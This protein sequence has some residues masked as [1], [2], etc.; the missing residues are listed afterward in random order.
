MPTSF[1]FRLF[2]LPPPPPIIHT[3]VMMYIQNGRGS[4]MHSHMMRTSF[5]PAQPTSTLTYPHP[6]QNAP[7]QMAPHHYSSPG[8][9]NS[10]P[11]QIHVS[12]FNKP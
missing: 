8:L 10:H 11:S 2:S 9:T 7:V 3:E 4:D 5:N 6:Y 1:H 12:L